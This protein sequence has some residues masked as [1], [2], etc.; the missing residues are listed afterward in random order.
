MEKVKNKLTSI[1]SNK[2]EPAQPIAKRVGGGFKTPAAPTGGNLT[3][4]TGG[5]KPPA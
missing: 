5:A 4:S 2:K 3:S 1:W